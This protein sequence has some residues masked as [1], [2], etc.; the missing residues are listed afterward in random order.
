MNYIPQEK[1][2]RRAVELALLGGGHVHPNPLVGAVI[3]RDGKILAEGWHHRYGDLHAERDC[4]KNAGACGVD[5]SGAVMYVTLEPC[6]HTGKQPPCTQAVIESGIKTV[7]IGS[8]DPNELV[9]GGGVRQLQA[10]GITVIQDFLREECDAINS[11]FFHYIKYKKPYVIVKYAMT[12]DGKT[13]LSSGESKW[14]TGEEARENVH[15]TR[16]TV[17]AVMCGMKTVMADNPMLNC[18]V[19]GELYTQPCRVVLDRNLDIPMDCNL[20]KT[21]AEIPVMVFCSRNTFDGSADS[22]KGGKAEELMKAGIKVFSCNEKSGHL[23]LED[24]L[25]KLGQEKID[26]VLVESG[27][28]LNSSFFFGGTDGTGC[29]V[30]EVHCYV[31]PKIAGGIN[32][33]IHSPVQGLECAS[34]AACVEF[35]KTELSVFGRDVLIKGY[36]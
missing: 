4:L 3:E 5:L 35:K 32:G 20:V 12:A 33:N 15:R 17:A 31:A 14:I 21:A 6:C 36:L 2:M 11:V 23:D 27:G 19:Q 29:L 22:A 7:V 10:A 28:G 8:R 26:S 13:S 1:F 25:E 16:G 30:N 18:R 9:N 24:V 34:L